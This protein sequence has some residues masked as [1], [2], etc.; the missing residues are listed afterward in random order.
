VFRAAFFELW[1]VDATNLDQI[2]HHMML[3]GLWLR[4]YHVSKGQAHNYCQKDARIE[5][6][7]Q[8]HDE[9]TQYLHNKVDQRELD[10]KN[11]RLMHGDGYFV[12]GVRA[13]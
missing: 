12:F 5:G 6:H 4:S 7:N 3:S 8:E 1:L 13:R 9:S 10:S 11:E 2:L